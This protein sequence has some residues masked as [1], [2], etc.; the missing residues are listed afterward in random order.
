MKFLVEIASPTG[1]RACKEYDAPS[2]SAAVRAAQRDL[3]GYP[4]VQISDVWEKDEKEW[5]RRSKDG[6]LH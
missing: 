1:S 4:T 2:P 5:P 6:W 3:R